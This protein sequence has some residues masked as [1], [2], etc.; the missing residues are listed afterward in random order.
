MPVTDQG[1]N[2]ERYMLVP[3]TL[4]FLT[5]GNKVLL[6]KGADNKRLWAGLY[7]GVGGHIEPGEDVFSAAKRE[8]IEETGLS[9]PN[10]WLCGIVTVDTQANPGVVIFI[11]RGECPEGEPVLSKE[12]TLE[13]IQ[14]SEIH[15][16]PL[17]ADLPLILPKI[18]DHKPDL[19]PFFAH[20]YYDDFGDMVVKFR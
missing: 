20:S 13:W 19:P 7:N 1:V 17:V 15:N 12:G 11:F 4:I 10:L 16:L 14:R 18:L 6:L 3:R 2:L 5:R 9:A 8:L